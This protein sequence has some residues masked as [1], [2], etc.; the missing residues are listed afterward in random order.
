M[1]ATK[2]SHANEH[3]R[4]P[5]RAIRAVTRQITNSAQAQDHV[6][7]LIRMMRYTTEP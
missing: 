3:Q 6:C 7:G 2:V 5:M 1:E 4:I